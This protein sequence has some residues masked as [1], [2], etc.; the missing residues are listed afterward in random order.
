MRLPLLLALA[1]GCAADRVNVTGIADFGPV[2]GASY[3]PAQ[4]VEGFVLGDG[5]LRD[6]GIVQLPPSLQVDSEAR[7]CQERFQWWYAWTE[8][9]EGLLAASSNGNDADALCEAVPGFLAALAAA[10]PD[11]AEHRLRLELCADDGCTADPAPGEFPLPEATA[12]PVVA[13]MSSGTLTYRDF[14]RERWYRLED[15]WDPAFCAFDEDWR[16]QEDD[17]AE[18]WTLVDGTTEVLAVRAGARVEV[19]VDALLVDENVR[20]DGRLVARADAGWCDLPGPDRV[21]YVE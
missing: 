2:A 3:A 11:E 20:A 16:D 17:R 21:V 10:L 4:T 14:A 19:H 7:T 9:S 18:E 1:A 8:A 5:T 15:A 12:D 13:G 6:L